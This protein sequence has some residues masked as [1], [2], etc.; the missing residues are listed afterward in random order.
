MASY[1][2]VNRKFSYPS[3]WCSS[4]DWLDCILQRFLSSENCRTRNYKQQQQRRIVS[5]IT[6]DVCVGPEGNCASWAGFNQS[7]E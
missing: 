2:V 5:C 7:A 1:L 3:I 6:C 4:S